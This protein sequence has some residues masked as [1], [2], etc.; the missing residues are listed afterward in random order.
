[1]WI[2]VGYDISKIN[3]SI[4]RFGITN[5]SIAQWREHLTVHESDGLRE[6]TFPTSGCSD[7]LYCRP[8]GNS[9]KRKCCLDYPL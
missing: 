9:S 8:D 1:M 2:E 6:E 5:V 7:V 3:M 4:D